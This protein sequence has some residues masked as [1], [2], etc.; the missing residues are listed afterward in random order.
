[1]N[2]TKS[3]RVLLALMATLA[4]TGCRNNPNGGAVGLPLAPAAPLAP[5]APGAPVST[6]GLTATT[7][8]VLSSG[9]A[10][11]G[12]TG[13]TSTAATG[14]TSKAQ[15]TLV[16]G[17]SS[18]TIGLAGGDNSGTKGATAT[19]AKPAPKLE[20]YLL[21]ASWCGPCARIK[22]GGWASGKSTYANKITFIVVDIDAQRDLAKSLGYAGGPVPQFVFKQDGKIRS[23]LGFLGADEGKL[24]GALSNLVKTVS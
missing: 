18:D 17:T 23:E 20:A 15:A 13:T 19:A 21:S 24:S 1:M 22:A 10:A 6:A 16:A 12:T 9:P 4:L 8:S 11:P 7:G 3:S 2:A 5:L 14:S